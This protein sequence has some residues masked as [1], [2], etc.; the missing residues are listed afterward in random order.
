MGRMRPAC[1]ARC[2][3][4]AL[5]VVACLLMPASARAQ[6]GTFAEIVVGFANPTGDD[7]YEAIVDTSALVGFRAGTRIG[8]QGRL[9]FALEGSAVW[10]PLAT[11]EIPLFDFGFSSR[12]RV[13]GGLRAIYK[14]RGMRLF[15]RFGA[16]IDYLNVDLEI[17][18]VD[19]GNDDVGF[20][21]EPGGGILVNLGSGTWLGAQFAYPIA[22]HDNDD[23]TELDYE[24]RDFDLLF[25]ISRPL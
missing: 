18:G 6:Q 1:L 24:S 10:Q 7:G 21:L 2:G 25:T 12:L 3:V 20:L 22:T 11:P 14:T 19:V 13:A 9:L 8:R 5:P 17:A 23:L 4:L 16:G 15:A